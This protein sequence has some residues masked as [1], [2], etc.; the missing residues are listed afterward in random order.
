M[1][2][3]VKVEPLDALK[4]QFW[5]LWDACNERLQTEPTKEFLKRFEE[6]NKNYITVKK[7]ISTAAELSEV[8]RYG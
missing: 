3:M 4:D 6:E 8:G 2:S 1:K 5:K 7:L